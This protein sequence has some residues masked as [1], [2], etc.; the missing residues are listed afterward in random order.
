M[1]L[2]VLETVMTIS[3][4]STGQIAVLSI[5]TTCWELWLTV[6]AV[7]CSRDFP[8]NATV[9]LAEVGR[10]LGVVQII[11]VEDTEVT[12]HFNPPVNVTAKSE[13]LSASDKE[14]GKN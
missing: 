1:L 13:K 6:N 3:C 10:P 11:E 5:E 4:F 12:I 14:D 2:G 7:E 8:L 9:T